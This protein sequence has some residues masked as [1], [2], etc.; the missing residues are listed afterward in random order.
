MRR[1]HSQQG[2][3]VLPRLDYRNEVIIPEP[4]MDQTK[5]LE[6]KTKNTN[7]NILYFIKGASQERKKI[8]K[9]QRNND[10]NPKNWISQ[11]KQRALKLEM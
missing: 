5:K 9:N 2:P 11:V 4:E 3:V 1:K 10:S 8:S 6:N 7:F